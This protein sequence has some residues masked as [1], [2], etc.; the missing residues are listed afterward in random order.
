MVPKFGD[1]SIVIVEQGGIAKRAFNAIDGTV[2]KITTILVFSN[3]KPS[4]YREIAKEQLQTNY[5]FI[6]LCGRDF[7]PLTHN[8]IPVRRVFRYVGMHGLYQERMATE[9]AFAPSFFPSLPFLGYMLF[10]RRAS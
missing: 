9:L 4:P 5:N 1:R 10:S 2:N 8:V 7:R 6:Y 3:C